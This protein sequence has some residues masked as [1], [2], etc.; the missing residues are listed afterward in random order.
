VTVAVEGVPHRGT[1]PLTAEQ[2]AASI[3]GRVTRV[4]TYAR[5]ASTSPAMWI[6]AGGSADVMKDGKP[7]EK[8][9]S[10]IR[11]AYQEAWKSDRNALFV[12]WVKG[13]LMTSA[14]DPQN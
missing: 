8:W 3:D 1:E 10:E 14:R 5:I 12:A 2:V 11:R 6:A 13:N 4:F 9:M 7:T